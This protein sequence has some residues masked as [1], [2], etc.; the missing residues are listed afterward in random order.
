MCVLSRG[1]ALKLA[2]SAS[3]M[4]RGDCVPTSQIA[5]HCDPH[6][7]GPWVQ[8]P[9]RTWETMHASSR[10]GEERAEKVLEDYSS[11]KIKFHCSLNYQTFPLSL[12]LTQ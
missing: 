3:L 11:L 5:G 9:A 6:M 4:P 12:M 8:I 2:V 1:V 7:P 10:T